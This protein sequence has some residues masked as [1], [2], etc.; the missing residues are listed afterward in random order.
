MLKSVTR[1]HTHHLLVIVFGFQPTLDEMEIL[2]DVVTGCEAGTRRETAVRSL[3]LRT[4]FSILTARK[5]TSVEWE[6]D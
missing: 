4:L 5:I 2:K 1:S 6:E 3:S